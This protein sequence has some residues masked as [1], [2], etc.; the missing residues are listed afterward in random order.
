M[1]QSIISKIHRVVGM[2]GSDNIWMGLD[3]H[4]HTY[5]IA[6]ISGESKPATWTAP[7]NPR[8]VIETLSTAGIQPCGAVD[9]HNKLN[10][11]SHVE[12]IRFY[13]LF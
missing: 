12:L 10:K 5:H 11:P 4:K 3:V 7:A 9:S 6:L 1:A 2:H 13:T 8:Q